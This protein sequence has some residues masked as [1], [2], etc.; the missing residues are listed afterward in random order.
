[1]HHQH[2][3]SLS[4]A[5]NAAWDAGSWRAV[6]RTT[7]TGTAAR[8]GEHLAELAGKGVTEIIYQPTG[9][10]IAHEL[11]KVIDIARSIGG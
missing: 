2:L 5:D 1:M 10:H 8:F 6:P 3:V 4:D 11:E 7:L 9:P